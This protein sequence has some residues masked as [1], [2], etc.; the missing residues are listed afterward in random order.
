M[1]QLSER[2]QKLSSIL[3]NCALEGKTIALS[4][5]GKLV[6]I[7]RRQ[8]GNEIG[9]ISCKCRELGLPLLSVLVV[10]KQT[11]KTGSG[12]IDEFYSSEKN[13][14]RDDEIC[15]CEMQKVY[16]QKDWS[17]L[18]ELLDCE[19]DDMDDVKCSVL[20]GDI[21]SYSGK[22][23]TRSYVLRNECLRIK[24]TKCIICGFDAAEIYGE[25]FL[26]K[27]HIHHINPLALNE[28]SETTVGELIPVCPNCHMILHSKKGGV[29]QPDEVKSMLLRHRK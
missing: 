10:Y 20:E 13:K 29:Y 19:F 6:G 3:I 22:Y 9:P 1:T 15:Q 12:F 14:G 17:K 27:I 2:Q 18:Y 8:V 23:R 28:K 11:G 7:G 16:A 21:K 26:G 25:S 24:G 4:N 5:L